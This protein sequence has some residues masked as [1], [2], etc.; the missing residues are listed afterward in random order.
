MVNMIRVE[1]KEEARNENNM[2]FNATGFG[3]V[4]ESDLDKNVISAQ[5]ED[6]HLGVR[7][8][9][10]YKEELTVCEEQPVYPY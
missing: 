8:Y 4:R 9:M 5:L 6:D 10:F 3:W 7:G 2:A 1:I